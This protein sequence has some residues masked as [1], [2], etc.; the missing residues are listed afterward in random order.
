VSAAPPVRLGLDAPE[1]VA[2]WR[3]PGARYPD[4]APFHPSTAYP[5][6]ALGEVSDEPNDVYEAVRQCFRQAGLDAERFGTPEWNPLGGLVRPG[7]TVL[8]KPNLVTHE[9]PRD[10]EGWRYMITHGSVVR[11]VGDYVYRALEG[12]GRI[13]IADAPITDTSFTA[14]AK[15]LGFYD[16]R[17]FY[18]ARGVPVELVDLRLEEWETRDSVIL[19]RRT[20]PGDP[21]GVVAFN[22]GDRSELASHRGGG[23]YYGA[24]YKSEEVNYHHTGGRH[25][26]LIAGSAI[27]AD[28]VFSLPKLKTHKKAGITATLKNL[29]GVNGNKN[30]LPHHTEGDPHRGGDEHPDPGVLHRL[31]RRAVVWARKLSL[32]LPVVG[33]WLH[34]KARGVGRHVFGD[35][36]DVIRSGN[37]S[38][39]DTIWRMCLDLN[40]L[41]F[42]GN[43]D[44]TL[45]DPFP[46]N[47]KRHFSL[48]DGIVAGEGRGPLNPDPVEAGVLVFGL[49]PASVDAACAWL[50]GFDP[51]LV[52]IV[53]HAF[54]THGYPLAEWG[55]RDVRLVSNVP[56]WNAALPDVPDASTFHFVPH[57]GWT[58]RVERRRAAADAA[59][60]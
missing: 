33:P 54:E 34:H 41:I 29:V 9:H 52:P 15:L 40:K 28:V 47:R 60:D 26:Y 53:R 36:E 23:H 31:E 1:R 13:V 58:G 45:R 3:A 27:Q 21:R 57:F 30:W 6:Y 46:G 43:P 18:T 16:I 25:E 56:E 19:S 49:H 32:S 10:P 51:D 42:Y 4:R 24:D 8:L 39:N 44:G 38:G 14:I 50:I 12:H 48:V 22:L 55:W 35:S 2:V 7:E 37:W 11:A 20:L 5:E 17:D 59:A